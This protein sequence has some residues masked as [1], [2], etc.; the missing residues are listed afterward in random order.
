MTTS[1]DDAREAAFRSALA[2]LE[3]PVGRDRAVAWAEAAGARDA[4]VTDLRSLRERDFADWPDL[5][6][7]LGIGN[8]HGLD[9]GTVPPTETVGDVTEGRSLNKSA[10]VRP[11]APGQDRVG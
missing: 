5:L 8:V 6:E 4:V 11:P 1:D 3:F 10:P 7:S 2:G 9:V